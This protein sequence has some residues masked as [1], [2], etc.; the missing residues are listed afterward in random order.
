MFIVQRSLLGSQRKSVYMGTFKFFSRFRLGAI[1]RLF[2]GKNDPVRKVGMFIL[3]RSLLG[4]SVF[5]WELFNFYSK[6]QL[7]AIKN[8][9]LAKMT[10]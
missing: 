5:T 4:F 10:Q 1:K 9:F 2:P 8:Y 7:G 3:Q 6:F